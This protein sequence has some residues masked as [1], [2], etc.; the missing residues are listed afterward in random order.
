MND[1]GIA[2][3]GLLA[4]VLVFVGVSA[5]FRR[6]PESALVRLGSGLWIAALAVWAVVLI[7][8][9]PL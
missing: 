4:G 5:G 9:V 8:G 1:V 3:V 6:L 7:T 2:V